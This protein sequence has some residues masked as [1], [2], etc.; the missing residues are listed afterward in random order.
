MKQLTS[1]YLYEMSNLSKKRT[2]LDM[3][4]WIIQPCGQLNRYEIPRLKFQDNSSDK[5]DKNDLIPISISDNPT[6]LVKSKQI[7]TSSENIEKLVS[8]IKRTR[9]YCYDTG[10]T[11]H[12][13]PTKLLTIYKNYKHHAKRYSRIP[14][15]NW[16]QTCM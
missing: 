7:K 8:W 5:I 9:T 2:G 1:T 11:Q 13:H 4:V 14:H 3:I 6:I 12:I 15:S 10:M 16:S